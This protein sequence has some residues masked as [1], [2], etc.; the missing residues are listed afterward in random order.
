M[1]SIG[2]H[3]T[4]ERYCLGKSAKAVTKIS[5]LCAKIR[6]DELVKRLHISFF[7]YE[8]KN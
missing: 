5:I 8:I 2:H 3:A 1:Y 7:L 6:E 4:Q